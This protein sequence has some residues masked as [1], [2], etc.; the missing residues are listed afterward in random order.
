LASATLR[1]IFAAPR[2]LGHARA[3]APAATRVKRN[4]ESARTFAKAKHREANVRLLSNARGICVVACAAFAAALIAGGRANAQ[5]S[6]SGDSIPNA[7]AGSQDCQP[8]SGDS[9][10]T[11]SDKLAGSKGVIC[12]PNDGD[13][14]MTSRPPADGSMPIIR[15]PGS[16]GGDQSVQPK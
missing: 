9:S 2:K 8:A 12:P 6:R 10:K 11:L 5:A 4:I 16:P 1:R 14:Q 3:Q 15:P 13:P 7:S